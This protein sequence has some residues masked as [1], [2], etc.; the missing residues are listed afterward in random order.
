MRTK[1]NPLWFS[2]GDF[3]LFLRKFIQL[4][5]C[6]FQQ[7]LPVDL[8]LFAPNCARVMVNFVAKYSKGKASPTSKFSKVGARASFYIY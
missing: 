6:E 3:L 7:N 5:G 2:K 8:L 1:T 4:F